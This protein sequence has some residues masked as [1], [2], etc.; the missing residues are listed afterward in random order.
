[1]LDSSAIRL[2]LYTADVCLLLNTVCMSCDDDKRLYPSQVDMREGVREHILGKVAYDELNQRFSIFEEEF[3]HD[4]Y[5][6]NVSAHFYFYKDV[7]ESIYYHTFIKL[8][9]LYL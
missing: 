8:M 3:T 9:S 6:R 5:R 2:V 1:M 4:G 7:N